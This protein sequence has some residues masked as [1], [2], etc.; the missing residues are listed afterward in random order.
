MDTGTDDGEDD[1]KS[2]HKYTHG[3]IL[4]EA[5]LGKCNQK[6]QVRLIF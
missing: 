6:L 5:P 4:P 2:S 1:I 3:V